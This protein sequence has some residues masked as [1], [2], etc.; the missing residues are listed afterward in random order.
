[1]PA[2]TASLNLWARRALVLA[3]TTAAF[4][5]WMPGTAHAQFGKLVKK[6]V[7]KA[8]PTSG[9]A[10]GPAPVYDQ[11]TVELGA[12]QVDQMIAGLTAERNLLVG[13]GQ[14]GVQAMV[15]R[16]QAASDQRS[17]IADAHD[18]DEQAYESSS[19]KIESC[20]SQTIDAL[21]QAHTKDAQAKAMS[22]P[23]FQQKY[24][25][26]AQAM[27]AANARG[28]TAAVRKL[29][30]QLMQSV[31]PNAKED[32]AAADAKCGKPAPEPA[33]HAQRDALAKLENALSDSI[34]AT[35]DTAESTGATSSGLTVPQFA[36]ARERILTFLANENRSGGIAGYS[37]KEVD[38]LGAKAA[39]L[40]QL[41]D[42]IDKAKQT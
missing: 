15:K 11:T 21:Q 20:R 19:S 40:H 38:A 1:M 35:Q 33:W 6:A 30:L 17:K 5:A 26:A 7:D 31:Y 39:Q 4:A 29:Q 24:M 28:D 42:D 8:A 18:K 41:I 9:K 14:N 23:A 2:P 12:P 25:Q 32:T 3:T 22:D 27:A 36:T 16:R 13:S 10:T 34:R 37:Q